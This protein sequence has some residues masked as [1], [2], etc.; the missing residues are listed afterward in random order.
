VQVSGTLYGGVI[1]DAVLLKNVE[2]T[3]T[4]SATY[5]S[6]NEQYAALTGISVVQDGWFFGAAIDRDQTWTVDAGTSPAGG[7]SITKKG[8]A[9]SAIGTYWPALSAGSYNFRWNSN[10]ERQGAVGTPIAPAST[11]AATCP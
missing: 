9:A 5:F 10:W 4:G 11:P 3:L 7:I 8:G 6:N 1:V 2:Q